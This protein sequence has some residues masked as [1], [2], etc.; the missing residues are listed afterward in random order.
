MKKSKNKILVTGGTS[1]IGREVLR[2]FDTPENNIFLISRKNYSEITNL[3]KSAK[4]N[5]IKQDLFLPLFEETKV[6]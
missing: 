3:I 4:L 2:K 6:N 5:F 1:G